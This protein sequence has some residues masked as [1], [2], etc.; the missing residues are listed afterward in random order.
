MFMKSLELFNNLR[1]SL[2][3]INLN[4]VFFKD[5]KFILHLL[6]KFN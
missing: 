1:E 5:I 2:E 6:I 3:F 4:K